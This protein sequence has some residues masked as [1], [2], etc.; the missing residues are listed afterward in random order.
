[1]N[2]E[3]YEQSAYVP[4]TYLCLGIRGYGFY[5]VMGELLEVK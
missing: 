2:G 1:M 4:K 3:G 5:Q